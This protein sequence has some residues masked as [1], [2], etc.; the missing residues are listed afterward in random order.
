MENVKINTELQPALKQVFEFFSD[1][2]L[3]VN[4]TNADLRHAAESFL[5]LYPQQELNK[6]SIL[7]DNFYDFELYDFDK[8]MSNKDKISFVIILDTFHS[9]I[10]D[11]IEKKSP[12][13]KFVWTGQERQVS[14]P[15]E[16]YHYEGNNNL[17]INLNNSGNYFIF[18]R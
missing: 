10:K 8:S 1:S 13:K 5:N 7:S 15:Y 4:S 18:E 2:K 3:N 17:N 6:E 11:F 16:A 14:P 12:A 9:M